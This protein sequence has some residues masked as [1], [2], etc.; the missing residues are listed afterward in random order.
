MYVATR[1]NYDIYLTCLL[2]RAGTPDPFTEFG[3][4]QMT[5]RLVAEFG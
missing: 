1:K 3:K 4:S 2:G 5:L